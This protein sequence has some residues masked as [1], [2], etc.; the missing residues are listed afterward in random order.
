M[1]ELIT[2]LP[3]SGPEWASVNRGVMICD[4]CCSVHRSLGRH[5][6]QVKH[7]RHSSWH[8]SLLTASIMC[9]CED[10]MFSV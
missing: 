7:L 10:A 1:R 8:L 9:L 3:I 6:S 5:I 2:Q 4:E